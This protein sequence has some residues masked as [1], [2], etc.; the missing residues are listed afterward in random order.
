MVEDYWKLANV[1][2][3]HLMVLVRRSYTITVLEM[4][5]WVWSFG[6]IMVK[7]DAIFKGNYPNKA[8]G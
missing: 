6:F 7:L 3:R 5:F 8:T 2:R 4:V 1:G